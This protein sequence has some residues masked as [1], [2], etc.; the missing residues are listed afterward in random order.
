MRTMKRFI[1]M[2]GFGSLFTAILFAWISPYII[3]WYFSPPAELSISCSPAV[4][5]AISTYRKVI[6]TGFLFGALLST[7]GFFAFFRG[8]PAPNGAQVVPPNSKT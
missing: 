6:F 1:W 7:I 2:T 8:A 5:W 4:E 3:V